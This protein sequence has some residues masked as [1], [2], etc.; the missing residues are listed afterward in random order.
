MRE[1]SD[2][3]AFRSLRS[4]NEVTAGGRTS[5][6]LPPRRLGHWFNLDHGR[7][8][9]DCSKQHERHPSLPAEDAAM[10]NAVCIGKSCPDTAR[11]VMH[12]RGRRAGVST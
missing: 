1:C 8:T 11:A 6:R 2:E 10:P 3:R 9:T 7:T 5:V 12:S 4:T